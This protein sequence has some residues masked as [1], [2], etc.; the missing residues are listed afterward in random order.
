MDNKTT[1]IYSMPQELDYTFL[2]ATANE[3]LFGT[4]TPR[5]DFRQVLAILGCLHS[6]WAYGEMIKYHIAL[7]DVDDRL[8]DISTEIVKADN[9][10]TWGN[11]LRMWEELNTINSE[12]Q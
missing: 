9:V 5:N 2:A 7:W 6:A 10:P 1:N 8:A 3:I 11:A 4:D 12:A